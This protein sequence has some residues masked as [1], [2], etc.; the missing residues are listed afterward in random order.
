MD[1]LVHLS[2]KMGAGVA[3]GRRQQRDSPGDVAF[4]H[5]LR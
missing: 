2:K 4:E 5:A 3:G 1:A